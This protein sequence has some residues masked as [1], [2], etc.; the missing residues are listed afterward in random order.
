MSRPLREATGAGA[1]VQ[2]HEAAGAVGVFGFAGVEAG[3]A[4]EGGLLVAEAAA[5]GDRVAEGAVRAG[6]AVGA[7][8]RWTGRCAAASRGECRRRRASARP[9]RAT[10]RS[11]SMVR[12]ALVTSVTMVAAVGA[13]GEVPDRARCRWCRRR[14]R[15]ASAAGADAGDVVQQPAE[16]GA[17]EVGGQRQARR[18]RGSGPGRRPPRRSV[19][20]R[21]EASQI[22]LVRVSCQTMALQTA[23]R[24]AGPRRRWFR[25]GW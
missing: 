1:G 18:G 8:G 5:D 15:P 6:L 22:G 17:G 23:G 13:A 7:C 10:R 2:Q 9:S 16:L 14:R 20:P 12:L 19:R 25:A 4:D 21:R 24:S 11:I 3:L